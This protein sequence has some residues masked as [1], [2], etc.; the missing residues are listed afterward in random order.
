VKL[1]G[2]AC[3]A[4]ALASLVACGSAGPPLVSE[5]PPALIVQP[6]APPPPLPVS[7]QPDVELHD[8]QVA[9]VRGQSLPFDG[10]EEGLVWPSLAKAVGPRHAGEIVT[11][12]VARGVP[13]ED[14][15]R[16]AWTVRQADVRVQSVDAA[17]VLHAVELRARRDVAPLVSGC[18]L[19]VFLRADGSLRI[20]AP[21]GPREV[22]GDGPAASLARSLADERARCPIK[23]VA[24]GAESDKA[25]WGPVFDVMLAVDREKSA[26][27]TRY[28]L[29]QAMHES[30]K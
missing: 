19:A 23:Y 6:P 30:S 11:I 24:F 7:A 25:P 2:S 10:I 3:T 1:G 29:G 5:P 20:A 9:I 28:V 26:G 4:G 13:V 8:P 18:H 15:E 21:G 16:A 22:S 27:D 17:G 14:L 12:Q